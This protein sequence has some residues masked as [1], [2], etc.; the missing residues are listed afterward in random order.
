[1]KLIYLVE[2]TFRLEDRKGP[3]YSEVNGVDGKRERERKGEETR[4][5]SL[6]SPKPPRRTKWA[7]NLST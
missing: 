5:P 7:E 3:T 6:R 1:M 2:K 4:Y